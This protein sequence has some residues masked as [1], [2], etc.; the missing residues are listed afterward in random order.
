MERISS[1]V[2]E[3]FPTGKMP[4]E[5]CKIFK[6]YVSQS[7]VYKILKRLRETGSALP[8]VRTTLNKKTR[9]PS[10]VKNT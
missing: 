4:S 5:I 1:T 3:L 7:G 9:T 6:P 8:K 10:L 2:S